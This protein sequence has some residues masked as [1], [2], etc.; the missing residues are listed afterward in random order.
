[1][2]T[3]TQPTPPPTATECLRRAAALLTQAERLNVQPD[4]A[5]LKVQIA[6]GWRELALATGYL[7]NTSGADKMPRVS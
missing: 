7:E 2:A 6:G 3:T 5:A 4:E 1:M